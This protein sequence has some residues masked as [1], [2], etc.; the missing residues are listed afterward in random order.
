MFAA[1]KPHTSRSRS[2]V[3]YLLVAPSS[4]RPVMSTRSRIIR[5]SLLCALVF[6]DSGSAQTPAAINTAR[7]DSLLDAEQ[8][9][10][11]I[12]ELDKQLAAAPSPALFSL[13]ARAHRERGDLAKS[14]SDYDAALKLDD[15]FGGAY[16]GRAAT[17]LRSGD[18][19]G[20]LDDVAKARRAGLAAPALLLLEGMANGQRDNESAAM[21][22]FT[23][24]VEAAPDDPIG[25]YYRGYTHGRAGRHV[26]AVKDLTRAIALKM[27]GAEVY[28][29]RAISNLALER[30]AEACADGAE[31]A[32]RGDD[33]AA[34]L[35][36]QY[37]KG[38]N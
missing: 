37:C 14:R 33:E 27:G 34:Q 8:W 10:Q 5:V 20:A 32:K 23:R 19:V 36:Q 11:A 38:A 16:A 6:P 29:Y 17:R 2:C 12:A 24:Y 22:A 21:T 4:L 3:R 9:A 28:R 35:M 1:G 13:R 18:A 26:D 7:V 15:K 25:W 31:A 30:T